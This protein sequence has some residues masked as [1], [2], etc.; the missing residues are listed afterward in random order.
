M[1][2]STCELEQLRG[3]KAP[4]GNVL[5]EAGHVAYSNTF[6]TAGLQQ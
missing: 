6:G 2:W 1:Q 5:S 4:Q 3:V